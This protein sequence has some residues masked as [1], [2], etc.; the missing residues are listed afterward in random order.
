M[1]PVCPCLVTI[2]RQS[3]GYHTEHA[4]QCAYS[5]SALCCGCRERGA[6]LHFVAFEQICCSAFLL[7]AVFFL[8]RAWQC[9]LILSHCIYSGT[10]CGTQWFVHVN[11]VANSI[12]TSKRC[13]TP[14]AV[15]AQLSTLDLAKF[16]QLVDHEHLSRGCEERV[17]HSTGESSHCA[18]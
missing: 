5:R 4:A 15:H 12:A 7:R 17:Q 13:V 8:N 6:I 1:L 14:T 11:T 2:F 3:H 9:M 18:G 10:S 16:E